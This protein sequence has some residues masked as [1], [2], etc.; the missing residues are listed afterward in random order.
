[1]KMGLTYKATITWTDELFLDIKKDGCGSFLRSVQKDGSNSIFNTV[2]P[3]T[4][5]LNHSTD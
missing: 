3:A 5:I 1:M 2:C 4:D